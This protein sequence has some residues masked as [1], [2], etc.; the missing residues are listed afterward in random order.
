MNITKRRASVLSIAIVLSLLFQTTKAQPQISQPSSVEDARIERLIGL[1]KVWG[2]VKFFHPYLAYRAIDWDKA[3]IEAIPKVNAAR[4]PSDYQTAIDQ[5]LAA[6]GDRST[7]ADLEIEK[8]TPATS[9]PANSGSKS[10]RIENRVLVIDGAQIASALDRDESALKGLLGEVRQ[11]LADANGVVID[12]RIN[13]DEGL[14]DQFDSFLRQV[15]PVMLDVPIALGAERYRMHNGYASQ[16]PRGSDL[17]S[18]AFVT[19]TQK[20]IAGR[21]KAKTPVV[22]IIN[23]N[24]SAFTDIMTGM[25]S[26]NRAAVIQV[27]DR[28]PEPKGGS[29]TIK[30]PE[31][32][33]VRMRTSEQIRSDG[34][35]DFQADLVI[36]KGTTDDAIVRAA[37]Q[38]VH[39]TKVVDKPRRSAQAPTA[40]INPLD[41]TYA[42]MQFPSVEYRL[43]A[44][45]RFWN[46]INYFF[47]YKNLIGDSWETVLP[48]FIPKF[49]A[50]KDV[51]EYQ[52]TVQEL[53][54]EI[55]DSHGGV[56]NAN[57]A[58]EKFGMF[59]PAIVVSG[60]ENQSVVTRVLDKNSPIKV[61]DA[62]LAIDDQPV[63][64]RRE[65]LARFQAASTPQ[66]LMLGV[67]SVLLTGTK[68]SVV[69][70]HVLAPSGETR[71][72]TLSR[73][74]SI[75]DPKVWAQYDHT[76]PMTEVLPSGFS[77]VD[78]TRVK[79]SDVDKMFETIKNTPA[80]IF[81]MRG[82]PH[83]TAPF[84]A[85]R[86]S[87]KK[88]VVGALLSRPLLEATSLDVP[89][90]FD[91]AH[92][93][94]TQKT[95]EA[96]G[97]TYKGKVVVLINEEAISQ[98][99]HLCLFFEAATDVTFIGTPTAG[100]NG[101]VTAM[102]LPG[103]LFVGFSGHDVRHADGRQLQRVG[104]Q[105]TLRVAPTI[106][107]L[108]EGRDEIL[109]AA[110]KYLKEKIKT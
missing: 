19:S 83:G 64:K 33:N 8:K 46:V 53:V 70:L 95:R 9:E 105:P 50:N 23:E 90:F 85:P 91:G 57:A 76:A 103:N 96:K 72:A 43:L 88:N 54:T 110:V 14:S 34:S 36:A 20:S 22:F 21:A 37:M 7:H 11:G 68:D 102:V 63:E 67:N 45:F 18:S 51:V 55:H 69:K 44:L 48:R 31:N 89:Y 79:V 5:M 66:W 75:E 106:R 30:L 99:E 13:N 38:I 84:I 73:T 1:A 47:P 41:K 29:F 12:A 59:Q 40:E 97:D 92:Y 77:Y 3:L 10:V 109:E 98:A 27:G 6:L 4:T 15:L 101:D 17:Y 74:I 104:I 28:S 100:A 81:D 82:Y 62:I 86:L 25:Q 35:S 108:A 80:V 65:Y 60:V 42:E 52:M 61:G 24:S 78:L 49:E 26:A 107:G 93:S 2:T 56:P 94:F 58:H 39:A 32:I 71:D 87:E 16:S